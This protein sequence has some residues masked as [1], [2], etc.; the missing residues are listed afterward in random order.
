MIK[1]SSFLP[2]MGHGSSLFNL[3]GHPYFLSRSSLK[4]LL[5]RCSNSI[6]PSSIL[7]VG[8]GY[9]PYRDLF[10]VSSQYHGLEIDQP[11]NHNNP[12]VSFF[13]DG[14]TFPIPAD[15]YDL[16]ICS[17]VLEHSFVPERLLSEIRRTLKADGHLLLTIPFIWPEHEQ[18]FDAQ[19]FTSFGLLHLLNEIPFNVVDVYKSNGGL[20]CL[21]Q[22][23]IDWIES[24]PRSFLS[25]RT[26]ALLIW[27]FTMIIPYSFLNLIGLFMRVLTHY[28]RYDPALY[29]DL[30]VL[31][32]P[33]ATL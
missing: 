21:I 2:F 11:R 20:P 30:V 17:Q 10:P 4:Y 26:P 14:I 8:C 12:N 15:S 6:H 22:L 16:V 29:I 32:K 18:P 27:R 31:C 23:L 13:Y 24:I 33:K 7:D 5:S 1:P 9:S 3:F 19:R 25:S 28:F